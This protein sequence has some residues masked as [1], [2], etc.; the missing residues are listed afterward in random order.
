VREKLLAAHVGALVHTR[1]TEMGLTLAELGKLA[2]IDPG[3]LSKLERGEGAA[4]ASSYI[5]LERALCWQPGEMLVVAIRETY[6]LA[7]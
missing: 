4:G 2:N 5:D 6:P 3:Q 1:R 7:A